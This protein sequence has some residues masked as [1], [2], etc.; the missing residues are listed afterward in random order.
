[1]DV[2]RDKLS[3]L[4]DA[5]S[6]ILSLQGLLGE[7]D[8]DSSLNTCFAE[9]GGGGQLLR[10]IQKKPNQSRSNI[11]RPDLNCL[12]SLMSSLFIFFFLRGSVLLLLSI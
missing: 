6:N 8:I 3:A 1:M 7:P 5:R 12:D 4:Y 9:L 11:K 2:A 10:S